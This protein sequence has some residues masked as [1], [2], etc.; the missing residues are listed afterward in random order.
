MKE[1]KRRGNPVLLIVILILVLVFII[2]G[3]Q[4]LES[5]DFHSTGATVGYDS[6]IIERDGVKY[7]PR[8]DITVIL[9]AGIDE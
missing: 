5:T 2:S 6:K 7:Y 9:V 8:Q 3:L 1:N 4:F